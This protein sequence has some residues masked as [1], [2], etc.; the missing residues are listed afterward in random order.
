MSK[1]ESTQAP[2]I[3]AFQLAGSWWLVW[4]SGKNVRHINVVKQIKLCQARSVLRLVTTFGGSTIYS[5][6]SRPL[7]LAIP[8]WV[9]TMSSTGDGF[10]HLWEEMAPLKLRPYGS[11]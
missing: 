4:R 3:N 10:G 5:G 1:V 11:L 9:N 8:P 7:S 6:H 2:H